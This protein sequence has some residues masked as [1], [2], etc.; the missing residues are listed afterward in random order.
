MTVS[1]GVGFGGVGVHPNNARGLGARHRAELLRTSVASINNCVDDVSE[2][3]DG[4]REVEDAAL[5]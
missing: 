3:R 2:V 5:Q 1:E 4:R